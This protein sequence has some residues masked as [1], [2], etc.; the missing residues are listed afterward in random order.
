V[1]YVLVLGALSFS[2]EIATT[3]VKGWITKNSAPKRETHKRTDASSTIPP[4]SPL[5][6]IYKFFLFFF[7]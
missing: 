4:D 2:Q 3:E 6:T 1:R 5:G 7:F